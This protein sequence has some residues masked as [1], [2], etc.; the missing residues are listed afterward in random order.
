MS[1]KTPPS[2]I[3]LLSV[4]SCISFVSRCK[5]PSLFCLTL[6]LLKCPLHR[7]YILR[8]KDPPQRPM[9]PIAARRPHPAHP[10]T[11]P[12]EEQP[13]TD[14]GTKIE[15]ERET[16]TET[17]GGTKTKRRKN[18]KGGQDRGRR[19]DTPFPV[20]TGDPAGPGKTTWIW[21]CTHSKLSGEG[22]RGSL[23]I[24]LMSSIVLLCFYCFYAA[25]LQREFPF[26]EQ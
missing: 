14:T 2:L 26:V 17:K 18:T 8:I 4:L 3:F 25:L 1:V 7:L 15:T 19:P 6:R 23:T 22:G 10:P 9:E 20:P 24:R 5:K 12:P 21:P 16:E 11:L 13:E